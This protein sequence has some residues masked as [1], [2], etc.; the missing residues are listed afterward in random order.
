MEHHTH[1]NGY[2][3]QLDVDRDSHLM[4]RYVDEDDHLV[5]LYNVD[6]DKHF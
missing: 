4:T 3:A 5:D 2:L 6:K 1:E